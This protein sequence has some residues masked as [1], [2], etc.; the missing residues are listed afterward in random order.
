MS[1]A[2]VAVDEPKKS[3]PT[4][5]S[6]SDGL[7]AGRVLC[8]W[9]KKG[10]GLGGT[11]FQFFLDTALA[12]GFTKGNCSWREGPAVVSRVCGRP[13]HGL[14]LLYYRHIERTWG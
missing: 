9:Q 2:E 12:Y 7:Y 13:G 4:E 6:A 3:A 14:G 10:G 8:P 1:L 5:L 11:A